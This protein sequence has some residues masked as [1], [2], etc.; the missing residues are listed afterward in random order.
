MNSIYLSTDSIITNSTV[1]LCT[2]NGYSKS[3]TIYNSN[4]YNVHLKLALNIDYGDYNNLKILNSIL[5]YD[6]NTGLYYWLYE[7]DILS[8]GMVTIFIISDNVSMEASGY[9]VTI[10]NEL[11]N[12]QLEEIVIKNKNDVDIISS[13]IGLKLKVSNDNKYNYFHNIYY[14]MSKNKNGNYNI[15]LNNEISDDDSF[16]IIR[17]NP[18]ITGNVKL[19]VD[20]SGGLWM[21]SIDSDIYLS[22]KMFKNVQISHLSSYAIDLKHFFQNGN[23]SNDIVFKL[24]KSDDDYKYV[25]KNLSQQYERLYTYGCEY[26]KNNITG[27]D[28]S[29]FA[30]LFLKK[31]IPEY[32]V[33]FKTEGALNEITYT[34]Y[35]DNNSIIDDILK[36]SYIVEIFDLSEKSK[37]GIYLRNIISRK[38]FD[39]NGVNVSFEKN[40]YTSY[41]GISYKD[42][43]YVSK[44]EFLYDF[45][46]N[47]HSITDFDEFITQGFERNGIILDNII[48]LEFLFTDKTSK[49]YELNRYFGLYVNTIDL[50]KMKTDLI[51]LNKM[52]Q[53]INQY[54][55]PSNKIIEKNNIFKKYIINNEND[56]KLY[57]DTSTLNEKYSILDFTSQISS[58]APIDQLNY[59][60][61]IK[62]LGYW[63][64]K[65]NIDDVCI[66]YDGE[67]L[68]MGDE[69]VIK[70]ISY[71]KIYTIINCKFNE[72]P[73]IS[74]KI[75]YFYSDEKYE[76]YKIKFFNNNYIGDDYRRHF[77]LKDKY[78]NLFTIKNSCIKE[79][80]ITN[81][82]KRKTIELSFKDKSFDL[83][84]ISGVGKLKYQIR[85]K[86][87]SKSY[88][89]LGIKILKN[90]KNG[91]YIEI[92]DGI[93]SSDIPHRWRLIANESYL[94]SDN[95]IFLSYGIGNDLDGLYYYTYFYPS[96][97]SLSELAKNISDGFKLFEFKTFYI[98]NKNENIY[99]I[100]NVKGI[101]SESYYLK[102]EIYDADT[103]SVMNQSVERIG[104]IN[105]IGASDYN[106]NKSIISISDLGKISDDDFAMT[107]DG[108][109][110]IKKYKISNSNI[111]YSLYIDEIEFLENEISDIKNI[112]EYYTLTLEDKKSQFYISNDDRISIYESFYP[113]ISLLSFSG[114]KDFDTDIFLSDYNKSYNNELIKYYSN[115]YGVANV[116]EIDDL[117]NTITIDLNNIDL[118][119]GETIS[120]AILDDD[121][122]IYHKEWMIEKTINNNVFYC[123]GFLPSE[124]M[125]KNIILLPEESVLYY[126]DSSLF[127]FN[128][129]FDLTNFV[130]E[131]IE[132]EYEN[133]KKEWNLER[134]NLSK[135]KSEYDL[136]L[137]KYQSSLCLKSKV[138]PYILKWV[139]NG[140]NIR[141]V[142]YRLNN[143]ISF[144][145]MNFSPSELFNDDDPN[146]HTHEWYY[147]DKVPQC[148]VDKTSIDNYCIGELLD[149]ID[150]KS[151]DIDFFTLYFSSGYPTEYY[152]NNKLELFSKK[153]YST[154]RYDSSIDKVYTFFRGRYLTIDNYK[155][156]NY[157]FSVVIST[158]PANIDTNDPPVSYETIVN[159]KWKFILIKI[160]LSISS[161]KYENGNISYL[162]LYT[163]N[164]IS[165]KSVINFGYGSTFLESPMDIKISQPLNL[166]HYSHFL[167]NI[168]T[169][170]LFSNNISNLEFEINQNEDGMYNRLTA[171]ADLSYI[172]LPT[173][174]YVE[175]TNQIVKFE[176]N[177]S[178]IKPEYLN[179]SLPFYL[180][181]F[182][183]WGNSIMFYENGGYGYGNYL[184]YK[185][186]FAYL[187]DIISNDN[188]EMKYIISNSNGDITNTKDFNIRC[189]HPDE[190]TKLNELVPQNILNKPSQYYEYDIIGYEM[191][192]ISNKNIIYR[193]GGNY[194]PKFKDVLIF[195]LRE[196]DDFTILTKRDYLMLNTHLNI[197]NDNSILLK[198]QFYNKVSN[199]DDLI[200]SVTFGLDPIYPLIDE[201]A[202]DKKNINIWKSSF[203]NNYYNLYYTKSKY[204]DK[205]GFNNLKEI[206]S[207]MGSKGMNIENEINLS[208]FIVRK[209]NNI[210]EYD[211]LN[212]EIVYAFDNDKII[213]IINFK[214]RLIRNLMG[215]GH[216][217]KVK[218]VFKN[219][220]DKGIISI[221]DI[222]N[223][224]KSYIIENI[225][226]LYKL[227][228]IELYTKNIQN[229]SEIF[230][231]ENGKTLSEQ[232]IHNK[233]YVLKK[234]FQKDYIDNMSVKIELNMLEYNNIQIAINSIVK[235]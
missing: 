143:S 122:P 45:F 202:I 185:L 18:K 62:L 9:L 208:E 160:K 16:G 180:P 115:K 181:N 12:N 6:N 24:D 21:N 84:S 86:L 92:S 131:D 89:S 189:I 229:N 192:N 184:K 214:N 149:I 198:N 114:L 133:L 25:K 216:D 137:E 176:N 41:N 63:Q 142:D 59:L 5:N 125:N 14:L 50:F 54:P 98:F 205:N 107:N 186:S 183:F 158:S 90:F 165:Q 146:Y 187:I 228:K 224:T 40:G 126:N 116:I 134:F 97:I 94:T 153:K 1:Y 172:T 178:Y 38:Y 193:Y 31:K 207:F 53:D 147:I 145:A 81:F 226:D 13:T 182:D 203:D 138:E 215:D 28:L 230:D 48:N 199:E 95:S 128:G 58:I 196:D 117:N 155:Y 72:D 49:N 102:Y 39:E 100:S 22:D 148:I 88:S 113:K 70:N 91:D 201:I 4:S 35:C 26:S 129:F 66:L 151:T 8:Q 166:E 173:V 170:G 218:K 197:S 136:L 233:K 15:Q 162:D 10:P 194:I 34:D 19:T 124:L 33:I 73:N 36:K 52:S 104:K 127:N 168:N 132:S 110:K 164:N 42:G 175:K 209:Y 159:E 135:I 222:D 225:I 227:D 140:S 144:G 105:F 157:K 46:T 118:L 37:I 156:N 167:N 169:F 80:N 150:F 163:F 190:L 191:K 179:A 3:I 103:I 217:D 32:F 177:L 74:N 17:T 44:K 152:N 212:D 195:D 56:I 78:G 69:C 111:I 223:M 27:E 55:I 85:S 71:D 43:C 210:N 96:D 93:S 64:D 130:T 108:F 120:F 220:A 234:D 219:F 57:F 83:S 82:E 60:Y 79:V 67:D 171:I 76:N 7:C 23:T 123:H 109:S 29:I 161:Y 11:I 2:P 99:F 139:K 232:N 235:K 65:I 174:E 87:I 154:F 30:P 75:F 119:Q 213:I 112:D 68:S 61:E 121:M 221:N 206:K 211:A 231:I 101:D 200:S 51:A 188:N 20:S 47:S 77:C 204:N 106:N 141:D